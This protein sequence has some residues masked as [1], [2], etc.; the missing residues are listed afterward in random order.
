MGSDPK[1]LLFALHHCVASFILSFA[2]QSCH[3]TKDKD[4]LLQHLHEGDKRDHYL[5]LS[6]SGSLSLRLKWMGLHSFSALYTFS[7]EEKRIVCMNRASDIK[8]F[9]FIMSLGK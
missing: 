7:C 2:A 5:Q 1:A 4:P 3:S 8:I 9:F 6:E